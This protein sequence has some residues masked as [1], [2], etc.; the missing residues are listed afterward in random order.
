[1]SYAKVLAVGLVGLA[2][3]LVE[4]EADLALGLPNFSL[5]GLP[6]AA[7]NE[8][9]DRVRAALVNSGEQ[10]P[11]RRITVNL[12]PAS[13]PKHGSGFDLA[14]AASV[15]AGA[16]MVPLSALRGVVLI[17]ELGLDGAVRPVQGVLAQIL[18][19]APAG[20]RRAVVP[21]PNAGEAA[22]APDVAVRGT[23]SLR[24]LIDFT[25]GL[26]ELLEPPES[27]SADAAAGPD[28]SDVVGQELGRRALEVAA[29]GKHHLFMVGPP[30][31]GK[32][33]LAQ[34]LPSVLPPLDDDAALEATA[35]HSIAGVLP[36][37]ARMIRRPPLQAPHHTSSPASLV[38][39]GPRLARPGAVSLAHH[40]VLFLDE[41]PEFSVRA[42]ESLRQPLESGDVTIRRSDGSATYP[43]QFQLVLAANPCPCAK[44]A[45]DVHCECTPLARRRY[46]GRLSGPLLDRVD[47]RVA[48]TAV[49]SAEL[50]RD[51]HAP[52]PSDQVLDRVTAARDAAAL[53]WA[54]YGFRTNHEVSGSLLRRPPFRLPRTALSKAIESVDKGS[55]SARGFDRVLRLAWTIADLDGRDRPDRGDV[56]EAAYLRGGEA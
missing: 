28:L 19:A 48:L 43:A 16:G 44:P 49:T 30:G 45:G 33:M 25:R 11:N 56:D 54:A 47:I 36:S 18:A 26:G 12:R 37:D 39:G 29:A 14:I 53:R 6:D 8:A 3:H 5:T 42:L 31:A 10:W 2:G 52:E 23:D 46:L 24:R 20:V 34:R 35:V 4:V 51:D 38:G 21:M 50:T 17:G 41:S 27:D 7:L 1:M 15:L 40:G 13:L 22:L 9:R 55:M 32:T